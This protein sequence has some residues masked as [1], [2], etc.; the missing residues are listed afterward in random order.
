MNKYSR[1][2]DS[3]NSDTNHILIK[4]NNEYI[5]EKKLLYISSN[6]RD[7]AKWPKS[8]DFE[9]M[10]P[11]SYLNVESLRL[12]DIQ[13]PKNLYNISEHLQNNKMLMNFDGASHIIVVPDG[14]YSSNKLAQALEKLLNASTGNVT[15]FIV[16]YNEVTNKFYFKNDG[17]HNTSLDFTI[18]D[19]SY[20]I[21]CGKN[22]IMSVTND[23]NVYGQYANWGLGAVLGFEKNRYQFETKTDNNDFIWENSGNTV[24]LSDFSG[25]ISENMINLFGDNNIIMELE[26]YNSIDEL[27]PYI[28]SEIDNSGIC[29]SF[30]RE[31]TDNSVYQK[32]KITQ[33]KNSAYYMTKNFDR[34]AKLE[35]NGSI[36]NAFAKIP[37]TNNTTYSDSGSKGNISNISEYHPPIDK[38]S[39][40]RFRFRYHNGLLVDFQNL[41]ITFTIEIGHLRNDF[42]R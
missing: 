22:R 17:L 9:I 2:N 27:T 8:N 24:F 10:C 14:L 32:G 11:Q 34:S 35:Y 6:D 1:F 18:Q 5:L 19:L 12:V 21:E 7:I 28:S 26:K 16:K 4:N 39:K 3:C 13:I 42:R 29:A 36:N 37:I 38:I 23:I 31:Y 40:M 20:N 41:P 33:I 25:I 15:T 30:M